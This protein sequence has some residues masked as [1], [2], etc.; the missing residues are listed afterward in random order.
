MCFALAQIFFVGFF[1]GGGIGKTG[2]SRS[3]EGLGECVFFSVL[4]SV[5]SVWERCLCA[6]AQVF[7]F[8]ARQRDF[9]SGG[10]FRRPT[11]PKRGIPALA[12][13]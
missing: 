7:L 1:F 13:E 2:N 9:F 4:G 6:A 8:F 10:V 5:F 12:T 3:G 11:T